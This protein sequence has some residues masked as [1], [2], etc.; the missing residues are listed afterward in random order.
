MADMPADFWSGWIILLSTIGFCGLAWLVLSVYQ[1][2]AAL[3]HED[4]PVWDDNLREGTSA[5]P[6]WWFWLILAAM[7]FSVIYLMLYPGLGSFAGAFKWSQG[8]QLNTHERSFTAEFAD[9]RADLLAMP[10]AELAADPAAITAANRLF[11]EHCSACHGADA[12]G[13]ANLFPNLRDSDWQWGNTPENIEQTIRNGRN[14][15]MISWQAVLGD[16]GVN[17]VA[18]YVQ[19]MGDSEVPASHPGQL[20]YQQFCFACHGTSGEGNPLLGALRLNDSI[21]L[22]GDD[23]ASI[24]TSIAVGRSGQMP[25]FAERLDDLQIRLLVAWLLQE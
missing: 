8:G 9:I 16:E 12:T 15:V 2:P 19:N 23:I 20:L 13:Q 11:R 7:V 24:R 4:E 22:Y 18:D 1:M 5:A 25:A 17:N 6:I 14:A 21:W 3:T 10:L